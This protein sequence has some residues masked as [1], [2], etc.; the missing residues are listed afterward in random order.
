MTGFGRILLED[1]GDALDE[2]GQDYL[3]RIQEAGER[4]GMMIDD[5]LDLSRLTRREMR[6]EEVDLSSLARDGT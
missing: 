3:R 4:M 1:Y 5:L 6:H 2:A